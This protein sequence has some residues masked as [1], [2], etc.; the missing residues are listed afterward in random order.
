MAIEINKEVRE[1]FKDKETLKVLA[2]IDKHGIPHVTFKGS[3]D[4]DEDGNIYYLEV[5]ESSQTNKNLTYSIWFD[6]TVAITIL[7]KNKRSYQIKGTPHKVHIAGPLFEEKYKEV[8]ERNPD[9]DLSGVWII[10]PNEIRE[11]TFPIRLEEER[12]N[13]PIIGHLDRLLKEE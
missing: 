10:K 12:K 3:V 11:E 6:K 13:H 1:L 7:G 9:S 4:I 2:S 8:I 5:L